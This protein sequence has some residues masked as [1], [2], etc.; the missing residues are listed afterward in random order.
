MGIQPA[1][2]KY[3]VVQW[4][5][6][7]VGSRSLKAVIEH[8]WITMIALFALLWMAMRARGHPIQGRL[9]LVSF[10][11]EQLRRGRE[12]RRL[13]ISDQHAAARH[14]EPPETD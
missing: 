7:N 10:A 4:A 8:P 2:Q 1:R 13:I 3:R 5:T 6:G 14:A 12:D 11:P 9:A